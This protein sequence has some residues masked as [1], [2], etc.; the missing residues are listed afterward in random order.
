M[1]Q[2]TLT[3]GTGADTFIYG[4]FSESG[5]GSGDAIT[6][7]SATGG[8]QDHLDITGLTGTFSFLGAGSFTSTGNT[9]AIFNDTSKLLQ[10][11]VDG[12]GTADMNVTLTGVSIANLDNADF[13]VH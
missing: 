10:V 9:E 8:S 3:G 13:I 2:D 4:S 6:N 7:F 12:N 11:D 1:G 5:V